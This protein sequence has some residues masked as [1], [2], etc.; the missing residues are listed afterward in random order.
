MARLLG[1]TTRGDEGNPAM[2]PSRPLFHIMSGLTV[3][4]SAPDEG[5][6]VYHVRPPVSIRL[7]PP[8]QV[9]SKGHTWFARPSLHDLAQFP[10]SSQPAWKCH[11]HNLQKTSP[12]V[13][14]DN[15]NAELTSP[16]PEMARLCTAFSPVDSVHGQSRMQS[17]P[18]KGRGCVSGVSYFGAWQPG[19]RASAPRPGEKESSEVRGVK[20]GGGGGVVVSPGSLVFGMGM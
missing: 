1:R 20:G 10:P 19:Y 9:T 15:A 11:P 2:M 12:P 7:T 5:L 18:G 17:G 16:L 3:S 6:K 13:T 8:L 4:Y 14:S